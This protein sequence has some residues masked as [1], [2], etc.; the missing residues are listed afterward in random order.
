MP[1]N[2]ALVLLDAQVNMLADETAVYDA[3]QLLR[4]LHQLLRQARE[5][6]VAI[7]HIQNNG[8]DG[9]PDQPGTPGWAIHPALAP[10]RGEVVLQKSSPDAF[11]KSNLDYELRSRYIT[12]LVLAGMQSDVCIHATLRRAVDLGYEV[13]L[14]KDGHSTFDAEDISAPEMIELVNEE[15][16]P[17]AAVVPQAEIDFQNE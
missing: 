16:N 3:P 2:T 13:V 11:A 12:R 1:S 9:D 14:V 7:F 4:R 17:F 8:G 5:A 15:L 6:G 10:H